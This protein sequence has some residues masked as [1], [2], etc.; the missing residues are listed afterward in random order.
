MLGLSIYNLYDNIL[1]T[2]ASGEN[3]TP[4][5]LNHP[6]LNSSNYFLS[7]FGQ[8]NA[9][10]LVVLILFFRPH[11]NV[12]RYL[13]ALKQSELEKQDL[14]KRLNEE[15]LR[16]SEMGKSQVEDD[17]SESKSESSLQRDNM[18]LL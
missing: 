1:E 6:F 8:A 14:I 10:N 16:S 15:S 13:E 5:G 11:W 9:A 7:R 2:I 18:M 12:Y 3:H 4:Y 17:E